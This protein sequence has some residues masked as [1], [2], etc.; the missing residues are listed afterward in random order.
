VVSLKIFTIPKVERQ[1]A[2][3]NT[4]DI[5]SLQLA[6]NILIAVDLKLYT[7][8]PRFSSLYIYTTNTIIHTSCKLSFASALVYSFS[9]I[10]YR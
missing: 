1:L 5:I 8:L 10:Q 6:A 2:H 3:A 7:I 9:K 4:F